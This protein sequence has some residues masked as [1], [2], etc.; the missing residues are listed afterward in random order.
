M[1]KIMMGKTPRIINKKN[2]TLNLVILLLFLLVPLCFSPSGMWTITASAAETEATTGTET[3][4]ETETAPR[5]DGDPVVIV[6]DPGHGGDN[7]GA[8][9]D[10]LTEKVINLTVAQAMKAELE[11]YEGVSVFL[12][13][14]TVEEDLSLAER[15]EFAAEKEADFLYCLHFNMSEHHN[16]DGAEVWISAF[17]RYYAD[18]YAFGEIEMG[19][20]TE[21]GLFSRG[22]KTRLNDDGDDYYGIIRESR[23]LGLNCVLIEHC[24]LD[25]PRDQVFYQQG[26]EQLKE[27][28][29]LDATAVAR[30]FRLS[31][32]ELGVDYRDYPVTEVTMPEAAVA[33]D[34]SPPEGCE[35][36][37]DSLDEETGE[38]SFTLTA[39]DRDSR[40]LYYGFSV[41]GGLN[42]DELVPFPEGETTVSFTKTLPTGRNLLVCA[43]AYNAYD[44][45]TKS[46]W[47][48]IDALAGPPEAL[49]EG[50]G[51]GADDYPEVSPEEFVG[52]SPD[53]TAEQPAS[54]WDTFSV[55][56]AIVCGLILL[57]LMIL[58][59]RIIMLRQMRRR[60]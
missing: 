10:G 36:T 12:T 15:A 34:L 48:E 56:I 54:A 47:I 8:Q 52:R 45:A 50:T 3:T 4:T 14:E 38:A 2:R 41:D 42:Y 30:Y 49:E 22:I 5:S 58:A 57:V 16:F 33:P 1:K 31:S 29:R 6:I 19:L 60:R 26:E 40:I 7:L 55:T 11:K 39:E 44:R 18:G 53:E 37:M 51:D 28:G 13:R 21:K 25:H 23:E 27:L 24:H 32:A 20:L 17:D 46:K 59:S 43:S 9:Q 35:L